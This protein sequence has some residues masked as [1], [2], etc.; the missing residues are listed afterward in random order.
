MFRIKMI[1]L[2]AEKDQT[3]YFAKKISYFSICKLVLD[4]PSAA[5][6]YIYSGLLH[7]TKDVF[8]IQGSIGS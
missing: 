3:K 7:L 8:T 2:T 5:I 6:N 4:F 1:V